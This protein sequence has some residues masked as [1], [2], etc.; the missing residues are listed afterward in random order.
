[1]K[2]FFMK[3]A[4]LLSKE[5][6][7]VSK[8]VGCVIVKDKRIV[9]M[10]YNGTLPGLPHCNEVFSES[11]FDR[12]AHHKWSNINELHAEMNAIMFAAKNDIGID[13]CDMYVTLK[14]C[15]Q[16]LKNII[17]A[18]IRKVYYYNE[19]DKADPYND[20]WLRIEVEKIIDENLRKWIEKQK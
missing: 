12:E 18:G 11:Q 1:M 20:L 5:S 14:P 16:C 8:Q 2:D 17:Q 15:D 6:K 19:Y 4:F 7:C 13:G 10:G 9:S 3:T